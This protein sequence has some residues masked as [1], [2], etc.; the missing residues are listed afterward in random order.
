VCA[1]QAYQARL[2]GRPVGSAGVERRVGWGFDVAFAFGKVKSCMGPH[3]VN[4]LAWCAFATSGQVCGD[5][6]VM[7]LAI[8]KRSVWTD[9]VL[10]IPRCL[11]DDGQ[12][13]EKQSHST[14]WLDSCFW[15]SILRLRH[16]L[17][18]DS[19]LKG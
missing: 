2:F 14:F 17:D 19:A 12:I 18:H 13:G 7:F 16:T 3:R 11:Q 9:I 8:Y 5:E 4:E 1:T 6:I 10:D 15:V